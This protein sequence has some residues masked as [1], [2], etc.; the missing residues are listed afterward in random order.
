LYKNLRAFDKAEFFYLE[1]LGIQQYFLGKVHDTIAITL[2][3]SAG[4]YSEQQRFLEAES[5]Y[6]QSLEIKKQIFGDNSSTMA[7]GPMA[8]K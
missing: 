1:A 2:N 7:I 4:L 5:T 3:N 8:L 6:I